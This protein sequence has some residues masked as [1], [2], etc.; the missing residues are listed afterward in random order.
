MNNAEQF[1]QNRLQQR[2]DKGI[3]RTLSSTEFPIDFSSNDYL[4]FARSSELKKHTASA[5]THLTDYKNGATGSRLLSGNHAF[6]EETER[7]IA[8]FHHAEAGLIFN[9][10]Y[11][12]NV[13]L[14]S[15]LAQR[16]DTII[17]D[18]LI[19]ASL[20][21][22]A[23]LSH[24]NRYTFKHNDL[25]Q[26]EAKLKIA[27]GNVYVLTES[28]YSM[29]GDIAPLAEISKLCVQY[30]AH[31]IVDEAHAL[32]IFGAF[33]SGL[34]QML[35]LENMVFA[36]IVTFGKALGCHGAIVLGS[37]NLRAYLINFARSFVYTTA[38][39]IHSIATIHSAYQILAKTDHTVQI[40]SKIALYLDLVRKSNV[41][42]IPSTSAIQTVLYNNSIAAKEA[43][44]TLQ[45]KGL[46]IRAIL[47]PTV[48]EGKERLRICLH[49]FNSDQEI[50]MLVNELKTLKHE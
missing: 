42:T 27:R 24:A 22:G 33:G 34:V 18:E 47:S 35:G 25:H 21:D 20:I 3:L 23:R 2:A 16:G 5:L 9:S 30:Q 49:L 13:G 26:L 1:I 44:Q 19:H 11:D 43:A 45:N 28:V 41:R 46:D 6:T 36:R 4:G 8:V 40:K 12:A 7:G 10:G 39:P 15:S 32:G 29:D 14:I 38:A 31:L 48:A 50:E 37:T 17:S